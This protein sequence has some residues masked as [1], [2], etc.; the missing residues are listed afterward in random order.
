MSWWAGG[1]VGWWAEELKVVIVICRR[2]AAVNC[3]GSRHRS[4]LNLLNLSRRAARNPLNPGLQ[5][6]PFYLAPWR[7]SFKY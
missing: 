6:R 1:L 5:S 2:K 4:P 7:I 3:G